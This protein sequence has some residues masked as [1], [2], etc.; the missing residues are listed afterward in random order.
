LLSLIGTQEAI[1]L[2]ITS[3]NNGKIRTY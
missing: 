3:W 1:I 2:K